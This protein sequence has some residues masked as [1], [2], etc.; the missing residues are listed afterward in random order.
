MICTSFVWMDLMSR[1]LNYGLTHPWLLLCKE[2][3]GDLVALIGGNGVYLCTY[4]SQLHLDMK[5]VLQM[6]V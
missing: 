2:Y 6:R 3:A 1:I 4:R 5:H